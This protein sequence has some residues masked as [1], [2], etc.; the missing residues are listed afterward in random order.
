VNVGA[1]VLGRIRPSN[2]QATE[3]QTPNI[4]GDKSGRIVKQIINCGIY[5][6]DPTAPENKQNTLMFMHPVENA[7]HKKRRYG[8]IG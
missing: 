4:V 3:T 6:V 1:S 2:E 8:I 5:D 7:T